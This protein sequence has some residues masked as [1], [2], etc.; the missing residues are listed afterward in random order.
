MQHKKRKNIHIKTHKN[1]IQAIHNE[2]LSLVGWILKWDMLSISSL[3]GLTSFTDSLSKCSSPM[4]H[5]WW[6]LWS[7]C[8]CQ[9]FLLYIHLKEV[10]QVHVK[11]CS[12]CYV[13]TG[14][15][16]N[17]CA[18]KVIPG[19]KWVSSAV[20]TQQTQASSNPR[21][22]M[23][24]EQKVCWPQSNSLVFTLGALNCNNITLR[25]ALL[26]A[27]CEYWTLFMDMLRYF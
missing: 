4:R 8:Y 13:I 25:H 24:L 7:L 5:F 11:R 22:R 19:H 21:L 18:C 16:I 23:M 10:D 15:K 12:L 14:K 27:E 20:N 2:K 26:W 6:V 17:K 1:Q 3:P 9:C